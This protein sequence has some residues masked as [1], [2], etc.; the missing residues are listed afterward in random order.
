MVFWK[1]CLPIALVLVLTGCF[2]RGDLPE[3][4][5]VTGLVM[6]DG[7]PLQDASV[8]FLPENKNP[9]IGVTGSDGRY[10]LTFHRDA[11]GALLGLHKVRISTFR[12]SYP[13]NNGHRSPSVPERVPAKYNRKTE[14]Q[15]EVTPG[16]Q[17]HNF[18]LSSDGPVGQPSNSDG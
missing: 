6:L 1:S 3:L 13:D 11:N 10:T 4:G 7:L 18:E 16:K 15:V 14:L 12:K 2:S 17:Q 8:E 5:Q 9:S